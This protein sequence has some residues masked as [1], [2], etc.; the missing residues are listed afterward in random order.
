MLRI[1]M[2]T[3]DLLRIRHTP[4]AGPLTETMHSLVA[5]QPGSGSAGLDTWKRRMLRAAAPH[6]RGL[7]PLATGDTHLD[8]AAIAGPHRDM[9][10]GISAILAAD[11][12]RVQHELDRY[13]TRIGHLPTPLSRFAADRHQRAQ[14]MGH[15]DAYHRT[16]VGPWWPAIRDLQHAEHVHRASVAINGGID[17]LLTTLHPE[18]RWVGTSLELLGRADHTINLHG[19]GITLTPSMFLRRPAANAD[20]TGQVTLTYPVR[21]DHDVVTAVWGAP[22]P[23]GALGS[24][25]GRSRAELLTAIRDGT[26]STGLLAQRNGTSAAAVSQ[27]TKLLR[28]AGLISTTREGQLVRHTLTSRGTHLLRLF[29]ELPTIPH[30][31]ANGEESHLTVVGDANG[32]TGIA[33]NDRSRQPDTDLQQCPHCGHRTHNWHSTPPNVKDS[34][35]TSSAEPP[36]RLLCHAEA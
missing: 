14:L 11:R 35:T 30:P 15:L 18:L 21:L 13:A 1:P 19:R 16:A 3:Q 31:P 29:A 8:L 26:S 33:D 2:T 10:D 12:E 34:P 28:R 25:L 4:G 5:L 23:H 6:L 22:P 17:A 7:A 24:V 36:G 32:L 9:T 20:H 27:Q